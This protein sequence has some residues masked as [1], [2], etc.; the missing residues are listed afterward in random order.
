MLK[1]KPVY[2]ELLNRKLVF[3]LTYIS[4][5]LGQMYDD[6]NTRGIVTDDLHTMYNVTQPQI[7]VDYISEV[8]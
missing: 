7:Y 8:L 6:L 1:L 5:V 3:L 4:E 2:S